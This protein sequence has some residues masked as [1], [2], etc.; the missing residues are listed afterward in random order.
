MP[1]VS[2]QDLESSGKNEISDQD[3]S[4]V[5]VP[6]VL[7]NEPKNGP[8]SNQVDPLVTT[9]EQNNLTQ[10]EDPETNQSSGWLENIAFPLS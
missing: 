8:S 5:Q 6:N 7:Q 10:G 2:S 9:Q 4:E 3:A 1:V